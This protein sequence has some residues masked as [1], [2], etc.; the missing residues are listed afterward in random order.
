MVESQDLIGI[1]YLWT[2]VTD[3]PHEGI[4]EDAIEYLLK[5]SFLNVTNKLKKEASLLHKKFIANC[6]DQL[7]AVIEVSSLADG[8]EAVHEGCE[9]EVSLCR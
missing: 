9:L 2:L 5:L 8:Q 3:C 4:A 7:E 6:Y 1:E